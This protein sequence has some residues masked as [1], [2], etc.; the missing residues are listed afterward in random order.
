M[1]FWIIEGVL[2]VGAIIGIATVIFFYAEYKL[3]TYQ[4]AEY[5]EARRMKESKISVEHIGGRTFQICKF[6][7]QELK[8][9]ES[10]AEEAESRRIENR[11]RAPH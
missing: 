11:L 9:A 4:K 8:T 1:I 3:A 6:C 7:G 2:I 5:D 10:E